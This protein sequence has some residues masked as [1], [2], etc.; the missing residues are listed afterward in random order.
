MHGEIPVLKT[1][2]VGEWAWVKLDIVDTY[3]Q[4]YGPYRPFS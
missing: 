1:Q 4:Q 2:I 3:S